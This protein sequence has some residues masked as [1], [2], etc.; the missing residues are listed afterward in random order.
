MLLVLLFLRPKRK[1]MTGQGL[2][3]V[4]Q[5]FGFREG[6]EGPPP[7][8]KVRGVFARISLV[9]GAAAKRSNSSYFFDPHSAF[10]LSF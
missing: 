4:V 10:F 7:P 6:K 5:F 3:V 8:S 2:L 1:L 9:I